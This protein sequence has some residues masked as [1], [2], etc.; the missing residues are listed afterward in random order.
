M[1]DA[2]DSKEAFSGR[3]VS[4]AASAARVADMREKPK[5]KDESKNLGTLI[6]KLV[7]HQCERGGMADAVDSDQT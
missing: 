6:L 2:P 4:P 1:A 7:N 3:F 5:R